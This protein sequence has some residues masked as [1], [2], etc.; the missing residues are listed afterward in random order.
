MDELID[1]KLTV[2]HLWRTTVSA[3]RTEGVSDRTIKK[4]EKELV[5]ALQKGRRPSMEGRLEKLIDNA[6]AVTRIATR[7]ATILT[8]CGV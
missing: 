7:V 6:D 1:T 4:I 8:M 3:L 5:T 2:D